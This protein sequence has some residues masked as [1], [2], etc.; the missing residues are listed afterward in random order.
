MVCV[1]RGKWQKLSL[2]TYSRKFNTQARKIGNSVIVGH[3]DTQFNSLKKLKKG[4]IIEVKTKLK[5]QQF[6]VTML[7]IADY[8]QLEYL[9]SNTNNDTFDDDQSSLTLITCY[10]F[11]SVLPNPTH[12]YIVRAIAI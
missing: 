11:D 7:R 4:D 6:K 5:R 8:S 9:Q 3:R 12:R 2:C 1:G 10:P